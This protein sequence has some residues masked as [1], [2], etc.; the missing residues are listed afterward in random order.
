M[1]IILEALLGTVETSVA[2]MQA[3]EMAI[4]DGLG[5]AAAVREQYIHQAHVLVERSEHHMDHYPQWVEKVRTEATA[6]RARLPVSEHRRIDAVLADSTKLD[7][8]F[9][10]AL[11]PAIH[12]ADFEDV[13]RQHH[14]EAERLSGEAVAQADALA[15]SA[16]AGMADEHHHAIAASRLGLVTGAFG[17]L[18]IVALSVLYTRRLRSSL[19]APL[20]TLVEAA[21]RF[22]N[23]EFS[24]RV[25]KISEGELQAVADAYDHMIQEIATRERK[26]IEAERMA[27]VGQFAAGIA[28]ELNNPIGVIRGYLKT[29]KPSQ[30]PEMLKEELQIL[31]EEAAACQRIAEDLLAFARP[32][33]V[34]VSSISI[35][36]VLGSVV[37]RFVESGEAKG[38][39]VSVNLEPARVSA[40][41]GRIRQVMLNLLRNAVQASPSA[42]RIDVEGAPSP[43]GCGYE[44]SVMDRG[45]GVPDEQKTRI[46]EPFFSTHDGGSGLGL[47]VC[48]GIVAAHGG[49]ISVTDRAGGGAVVHV[50][51]PVT[52][53]DAGRASS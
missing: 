31:D 5:L 4:R 1:C 29:M 38:R 17:M 52:A 9:R 3:D 40:D 16:E 11:L 32:G 10:S 47:A 39:T 12:R 45:V 36:E 46:F 28:H 6:L 33:E 37:H 13:L 25:G 18:S 14:G 30:P 20:A 22:G 34:S 27:V 48:H 23:G 26:L 50:S 8:L 42:A 19:L 41:S 35:D 44:F 49:S 43:D 21:S 53:A 51:L 15:R 2:K 24:T 7:Q